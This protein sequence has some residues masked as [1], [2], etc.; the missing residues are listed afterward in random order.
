MRRN[1]GENIEE[2]KE[3]KRK[4]GTEKYGHDTGF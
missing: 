4:G 2:R 1:P 3:A